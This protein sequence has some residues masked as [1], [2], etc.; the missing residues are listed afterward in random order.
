LLAFRWDQLTHSIDESRENGRVL[1]LKW[2]RPFD[3]P[4]RGSV[5]SRRAPGT[6]GSNT[7]RRATMRPTSTQF[8]PDRI[9]W[10]RPRILSLVAARHR[11]GLREETPAIFGLDRRRAGIYG[12]TVHDL[13]ACPSAGGTTAKHC[14]TPSKP[15]ELSRRAIADSEQ[16]SGH[17]RLKCC[18]ELLRSWS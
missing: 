12:V 5:R 15:H 2:R 17:R 13:P 10:R 18:I 16:L 9:M 1:T 3:L 8:K 11:E 4:S 6:G 7:S 14:V